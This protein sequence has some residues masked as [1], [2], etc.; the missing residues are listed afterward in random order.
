MNKEK[1]NDFNKSITEI[2]LFFTSVN[3]Y[4]FKKICNDQKNVK[5]RKLNLSAGIGIGNIVEEENRLIIE[6]LYYV[7]SR[8]VP[9]DI[10]VKLILMLELDKEIKEIKTSLNIDKT[11][12]KSIIFSEDIISEIDKKISLLSTLFDLNLALPS[13]MIGN[14]Q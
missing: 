6:F 12:Y 10:N 14:D 1:I 8:E 5:K 2:N 4:F 9:I 3:S 13:K 7:T 11:D